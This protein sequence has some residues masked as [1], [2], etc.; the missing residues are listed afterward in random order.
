VFSRYRKPFKK[1]GM[2]RNKM[3]KLVDKATEMILD[4]SLSEDTYNDEMMDK[5]NILR[6]LGNAC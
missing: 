5:A 6:N 1:P 2:A 3:M 4:G